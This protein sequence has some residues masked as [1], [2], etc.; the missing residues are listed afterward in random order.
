[1]AKKLMEEIKEM[2]TKAETSSTSAHSAAEPLATV[3]DNDT[4]EVL[5]VC[6]AALDAGK[7]AMIACTGCD[8]FLKT[9]R[10]TID[11]A[12]DFKEAN[13]KEIEELMPRIAA[14]TKKTTEALDKAKEKKGNIA[15]K[16][17][18]K[19]R[20]E[21]KEA[22]FKQYDK[23]KDG[24]LNGKEVKAYAK[25]QF[26]FV[27]PDS[28]LE[29]I[30]RQLFCAGDKKGVLPEDFQLLKTAVGIA[31]EE[32]RCKAKREERLEKE[33]KEAEAKEKRKALLV[34]KE[35]EFKKTLQTLNDEIDGNEEK[36][37]SIC[38]KVDGLTKEGLKAEDMKAI[39]EE[40]D[41]PLIAVKKVCDS[42]KEAVAGITKEV[43]EEYA[44]LLEAMKQEIAKLGHKA[45]MQSIRIEKAVSLISSTKQ[46][47]RQKEFAEFEAVR[48]EIAAKLRVCAEAKGTTATKLFDYIIGDGS[49]KLTKNDVTAFLKDCSMEFDQ[50]RI[51]KLFPGTPGL[52]NAEDLLEDILESEVEKK[53]DKENK[54]DKKDEEKKDEKKEYKKRTGPLI[55]RA[56]F[57]AVIR[58]FYKVVKEI[59]LSNNLLIEQS[60]Q[61]RRMD[62]GEVMEVQ[63][64]PSL[65]TSVGVYR[66]CGKVM[67]DG[68]TGWVTVA[69]NQ[70]ITFL[71]PG[72][73]LWKVSKETNLTVELKD[74]DKV[75]RQLKLG[76]VIEVVEWARTSSS[77]LGITRIK[78][79]A[80]S[81]GAVGWATIKDNTGST[82]LEVM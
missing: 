23:D 31:R 71:L 19:R 37:T 52:G 7:A 69:G 28:N 44:E 75:V 65:D 57:N 21:K 78:A 24:V 47:Q 68:A 22:L 56:D 51:D 66:V 40:A 55:S 61:I 11:E 64:G 39:L 67:K 35:E 15:K 38:D 29:R 12:E 30:E 80:Q 8:E 2:V 72:G 49:G 25:E 58:I 77:A 73:N 34:E 14:S 5:R 45:T 27:L 20:A 54:D 1:M 60:G 62:V 79:K 43:A 32:D 16:I 41:E 46:I 17:A 74:E 63:R 3:N 9:K 59:V 6:K 13:G 42:V 4:I 36:A 81:D 18:M 82:F 53:D 76:E 26:G 50:A 33:R 10:A 70:G 48:M